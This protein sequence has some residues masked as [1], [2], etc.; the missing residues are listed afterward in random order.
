MKGY[1]EKVNRLSYLIS[2]TDV[3]HRH[4]FKSKE[5]FVSTVLDDSDSCTGAIQD[6]ALLRERMYA[7]LYYSFAITTY[8]CSEFVDIVGHHEMRCSNL[9]RMPDS[10]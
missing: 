5:H 2:K 6:R 8:I 9:M 3:R 10:K 1:V 7:K 4:K